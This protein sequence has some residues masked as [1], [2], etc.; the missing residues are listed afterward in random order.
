MA[1]GSVA[2]LGCECGVT[3]CWPLYA[4]VEIADDTVGVS[5]FFQPYRKKWRHEG[6]GPFVFTRLQVLRE[7]RAMLSADDP[8]RG[9]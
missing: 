9:A 3:D 4:R 1:D 6:L 8:S 2:F 5:G 7:I